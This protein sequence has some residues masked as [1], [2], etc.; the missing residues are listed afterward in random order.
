MFFE[1]LATELV[2]HVFYSCDS[3]ADVLNLSQTCHRFHRIFIGSQKLPVLANAAEAEYGPLHEIVQLVT[4]NASQPA[5]KVRQAPMS[6]NLLE[7][8]VQVG[9]VARRWEEI[10]PI[11]KWKA[12]YE[13]R[14]LLTDIERFRLRRAIYRLWL[15]SRAFHSPSFP[16]T[17]RVVPVIVRERAELLHNWSTSELAEM[18]DVRLVI[19]DVVQNHICP[20]NGTIQRKFHKRYPDAKNSLLFNIHLNYPPPTTEFITSSSNHNSFDTFFFSSRS[21]HSG[22]SDDNG[23]FCHHT[24]PPNKYATK[25]RSDLYHEPG[26]EGWGDEIPHYYVVE[27][28]LKLDP[29]QVLWLRENTLLKEHVERYIKSM[30]EWFENNGE[31]FA[32]TLEWVVNERGEDI[33]SFREAISDG[34]LGIARTG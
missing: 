2:L 4:Q 18:E 23:P 13:N 15:Y 1:F 9:R 26:L 7:Q 25:F 16:R 31:T 30:G 14:R 22:P 17:S 29:S 33:L 27:D 28:M 19:R 6:T 20:S 21:S 24:S 3:I 10:Y 11:K 32:Q 12:D 5:H 34:E 8:I